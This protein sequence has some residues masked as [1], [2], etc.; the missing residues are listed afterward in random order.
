MLPRVVMP[1][2]KKLKVVSSVLA[3]ILR[4]SHGKTLSPRELSIAERF[5]KVGITNS[6]QIPTETIKIFKNKNLVNVVEREDGVYY[7]FDIDTFP[8]FENLASEI[9][10]T[11]ARKK[12]EFYK[13]SKESKRT[14]NKREIIPPSA[15]KLA[16]AHQILS[17]STQTN[18]TTIKTLSRGERFSIGESCYFMTDGCIV[19]EGR[20]SLI[21]ALDSDFREI[22][23]GVRL[24]T[25]EETLTIGSERVFHNVEDLAKSL[26]RN[27]I[28][29]K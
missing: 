16:K 23:Y 8:D 17:G 13:K 6:T 24:S 19:R 5:D 12:R 11:V 10:D 2:E 29:Y 25:T 14:Y 15:S 7:R 22:V 9:I 27:V 21:E 3:E 4:E 28:R 26:V 20:I 1:K 18:T